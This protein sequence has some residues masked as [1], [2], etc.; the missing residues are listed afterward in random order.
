M[1]A[2]L[3][4]ALTAVGLPLALA[5]VAVGVYRLFAFWEPTVPALAALV[6]LPHAGNRLERLTPSRP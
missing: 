1:D 3:T 2:A 5:L 4:F 6:F